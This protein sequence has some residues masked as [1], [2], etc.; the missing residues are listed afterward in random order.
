[1]KY[2]QELDSKDRGLVSAEVD[3]YTHPLEEITPHLYKVRK[4]A[5]IRNRYN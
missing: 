3:K 1:M 4:K 5:K 2:G